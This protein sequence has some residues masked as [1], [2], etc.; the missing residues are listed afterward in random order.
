MLYSMCAGWTTCQWWRLATLVCRVTSTG[1]TTIAWRTDTGRCPC[2]GWRWRAWPMAS[3][4]SRAMWSV[5]SVWS[6]HWHSQC[7]AWTVEQCRCSTVHV[8]ADFYFQWSLG[9]CLWELLTRGCSPYPDVDTF[10][11]KQYV[12]SGRR[13]SQPEHAP[14]DVW[15]LCHCQFDP[16]VGKDTCS[17]P[18]QWFK[19]WQLSSVVGP[20]ILQIQA[21]IV[22]F[23]YELLQKCWLENPEDRPDFTEVYD[24]LENILDTDHKDYATV[25]FVS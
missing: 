23:R 22:N 2:A 19:C 1:A 21:D 16:F 13:L 7:C 15:V 5:T 17:D 8:L 12:C 10:N 14:D 6:V 24:E 9:V 4:R 11:I 25:V 18:I 20:W 3:F